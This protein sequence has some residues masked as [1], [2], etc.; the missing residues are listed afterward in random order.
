MS[1]LV[2]CSE[3]PDGIL[4]PLTLSHTSQ[5]DHSQRQAA[6]NNHAWQLPTVAHV[7]IA[8]GPHPV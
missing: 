6:S 8:K 4:S 1:A 7:N 5:H 3:L 2:C